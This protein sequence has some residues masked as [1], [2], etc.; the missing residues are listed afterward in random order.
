MVGEMFI[1]SVGV[2]PPVCRPIQEPAHISEFL[3]DGGI[4]Q[5]GYGIAVILSSLSL[6]LPGS[7]QYFLFPKVCHEFRQRLFREV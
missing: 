7:S 2:E 4:L 1:R 6:S 5:A 3:F